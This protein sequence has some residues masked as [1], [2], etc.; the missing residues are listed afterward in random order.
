MFIFLDESGNLNKN[1]GNYFLVGSYTIGDVKRITNAFRK[2]QHKK[3]PRLLKYRAEVKFNDAKLN[4]QLRLTTLQYLAKQDCRIFYTYLQINNIPEQ[5]REGNGKFKTGLL[6]TEIVGETME[7]YLPV[8]EIELRI[9]RDQRATKGITKAQFNE[10]LRARLLPQLPAKANLQIEAVDSTTS[11]AVQVADWFCGA[12]ARY[13]EKK[14]LGE[15]FYAVLKG[16][17]V[18]QKELF[19]EYWTKKWEAKP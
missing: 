16:N 10:H 19:S 14:K 17:I 7:L 18:Q 3:F 1:N 15:E 4:D 8:T 12:L 11:P 9:F 2:W 13:H 6:Y 5:Y